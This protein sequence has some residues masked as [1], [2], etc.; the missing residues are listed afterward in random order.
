MSKIKHDAIAFNSNGV[1]YVSEFKEPYQNCENG[2]LDDIKKN[3]TAESNRGW[4]DVLSDFEMWNKKF[5]SMYLLYDISYHYNND[6]PYSEIH[7]YGAY[8]NIS[9]LGERIRKWITSEFKQS[10]LYI[11]PVYS[12]NLE[13]NHPDNMTEMKNYFHIQSHEGTCFK[14]NFED[15]IASEENGFRTKIIK[16][17]YIESID[18]NQGNNVKDGKDVLIS[19]GDEY[20]KA[21]KDYR[22]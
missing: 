7:F 19:L 4:G 5:P 12:P 10:D 1:E 16:T 13:S 3:Y 8:D 21:M 18:Y 6:K 20:V 17:L 15:S 14:I 9:Y 11:P 22:T 2:F